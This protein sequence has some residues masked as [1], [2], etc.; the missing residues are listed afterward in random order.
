MSTDTSGQDRIKK[1]AARIHDHYAEYEP[2]PRIS[3]DEIGHFLEA[4]LGVIFPQRNR[5]AGGEGCKMAVDVLEDDLTAI[6]NELISL[7]KRSCKS[8]DEKCLEVADRFIDAL[9]DIAEAVQLDA[10]ALQ[11]GDPAAT[12]ITEIVLSYPGCY[13]VATYRIANLFYGEGVPLFP[14]LLTEYAHSRTGIDINPGATIGKSLYIDHG[15]AVVIGETAII[16]DNVKIYQGVTIG[17]LRIKKGDRTIKRHPT[18]EDNVCI[19]ANATILGGE[20]VVGK[21]SIIGGNV[22]LTKS[23]AE[24]SRIMYEPCPTTGEK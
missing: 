7:I 9:P 18:I 8:M 24:N 10:K 12:S 14:R 6:Y 4:T 17:A 13:A 1:A 19:Y 15:T 16:G 22:W 20:T 21:N 5:M 11:D 2:G 23:V 3:M